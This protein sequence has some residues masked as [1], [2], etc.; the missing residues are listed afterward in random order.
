M[1]SKIIAKI[2]HYKISP[3]TVKTVYLY[4]LDYL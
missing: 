1:E 2:L 4:N 3:L